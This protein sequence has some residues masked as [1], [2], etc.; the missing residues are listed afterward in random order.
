LKLCSLASCSGGNAYLISGR[1]GTSVLVDCGLSLRRLE[2]GLLAAGV[3]PD[4]LA[5]VFMTHEHADHV[6]A[7]RLRHPFPARH[8]LPVFAPPGF[9]EAFPARDG[10]DRR[11]IGSR[12]SVT[13]GG[14][15]VTA[16]PKPHDAAEPVGYL[17]ED[18]QEAVGV[19]TDLGTVTR[20]VLT[21][22]R[23]ADHLI[24]E[25]NHDPVLEVRSGRPAYLIRRVLS[26]HGHLSN[27]QA[28][29]ALALLASARTR[30]ILLAHLSEDCNL[31]ELALETVSECLAGSPFRGLLATAPHRH[32]SPIYSRDG[33]GP[34]RADN[35]L[36]RRHAADRG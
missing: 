6:Q 19:A 17:V 36:T 18:G 3:C 7:L 31:P 9:W 14:L 29:Q 21:A 24:F 34:I 25:S 32:P 30:T 26:D 1:D 28:G 16:F 27:Q 5:G 22:L 35:D 2:A 10:L 11:T 20:D 4:D 15:T 33:A 12:R 23:G 8:G 13:V